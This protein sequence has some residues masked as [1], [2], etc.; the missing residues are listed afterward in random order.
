MSTRKIVSFCSLLQ[1]G[2]DEMLREKYESAPKGHLAQHVTHRWVSASK[3]MERYL[4]YHP[5][6]ITFFASR[7]R[8][9]AVTNKQEVR[10]FEPHLVNTLWC[11]VDIVLTRPTG[12]CSAEPSMYVDGI[13]CGKC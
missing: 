7:S 12:A 1:I 10:V 2:F 9:L 3:A 13:F 4:V 11:W 8:Q 6:L 5:D